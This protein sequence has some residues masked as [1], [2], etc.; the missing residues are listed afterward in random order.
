MLLFKLCAQHYKHMYLSTNIYTYT[1]R[2]YTPLSTWV[3]HF[4]NKSNN[5][6]M[7]FISLYVD[8]FAGFSFW[9]AFLFA[10]AYNVS[11]LLVFYNQLCHILFLCIWY[12]CCCDFFS[13]C[14][15]HYYIL[16]GLLCSHLQA[17]QLFVFA[18]FVF[19]LCNCASNPTVHTRS[20]T[21]LHELL[22]LFF[23]Q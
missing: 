21:Y 5:N 15:C 20:H 2:V 7:P 23:Y 6:H 22:H 19:P 4:T 11:W 10:T 8:L 17:S 3:R 16:F 14:S 9:F 12:C 18:V 1:I 13:N